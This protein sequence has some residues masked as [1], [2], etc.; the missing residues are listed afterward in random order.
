MMLIISSGLF[1]LGWIKK[2]FIMM[3]NDSRNVGAL[4]GARRI[5]RSLQA[6]NYA[7]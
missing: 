6:G 3:K 1:G 7:G 5:C 4:S 2:V